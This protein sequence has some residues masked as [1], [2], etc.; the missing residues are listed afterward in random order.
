MSG[1]A[2]VVRAAEPADL[3]R[4]VARWREMMDAHQGLDA[5][6][7]AVEP[8]A[9]QS[10]RAFARRQMQDHRGLLL[11]ADLP[12]DPVVG[13]LLGG[14]GRRAPV[15]RVREVGMVFDLGV[16]PDQRRTGVGH[17]LVA[18]AERR[19]HGW[20]L[21]W[22]QADFAPGNAPATAFWTGEGFATLL[23]EAYRSIG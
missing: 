8:H 2:A 20:G 16:R 22:I 13:Y 6:L 23:C 15:Y 1:S 14:L 7:Y 9:D 11:V 19:F 17:A 12:G 21:R 18:A 4:V 3:D 10:Y 5:E